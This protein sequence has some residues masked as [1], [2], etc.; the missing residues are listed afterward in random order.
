[1]LHCQHKSRQVVGPI[2]HKHPTAWKVIL[3][4]AEKE[5]SLRYVVNFGDQTIIKSSEPLKRT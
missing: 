2:H 4:N 1:M 3:V 5:S